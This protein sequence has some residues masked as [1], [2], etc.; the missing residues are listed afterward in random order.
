MKKT[1]QKNLNRL[2]K[3]QEMHNALCEKYDKNIYEL[4][5]KYNI[6]D[7]HFDY[8]FSE[9]TK[10]DNIFDDAVE[11]VYSGYEKSQQIIRA[12]WAARFLIITN[13]A[14]RGKLLHPDTAVR[15]LKKYGDNGKYVIDMIGTPVLP[16]VFNSEP[17]LARELYNSFHVTLMD[18]SLLQYLLTKIR[19]L[20]YIFPDDDEYRKKQIKHYKNFIKKFHKSVI[21]YQN[22]LSREPF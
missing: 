20:E 9:W 15:K 11:E 12:K 19:N 17:Y 22:T 5:Q 4:Q 2:T 14:R 3:L 13:I 7:K 10:N 1:S 21:E 16:M 18:T 8:K 6:S